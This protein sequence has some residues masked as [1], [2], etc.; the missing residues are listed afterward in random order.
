MP[1]SPEDLPQ[2]PTVASISAALAA[3][4]AYATNPTEEDLA[5]QAAGVGGEGVL[6]CVLAN[7]LYGAAISTGLLAEGYMLADGGTDAQLTTAR[8]QVLKAAGA[9]GPGVMGVM[10]WQAVQIAGPLRGWSRGASLGP[11]GDAAAD[12][13]WAL[14]LLL[15]ASTVT[16]P[17]DPRFSTLGERVTEAMDLLGSARAHLQGI[18]DDAADVVAAARKAS[19]GPADLN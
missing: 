12:A 17:D 3:L 10:H 9:T 4:G 14:M 13:A 5:R 19:A 6:A 7:A 8:E 2:R 1:D 11:L 18:I 15:A 16:R